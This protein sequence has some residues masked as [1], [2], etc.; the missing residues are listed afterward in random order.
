MTVVASEADGYG[1]L[2][3]GTD[4]PTCTPRPG[5]VG[6]FASL[7]PG[8]IVELLGTGDVVRGSGRLTSP[9]EAMRLLEVGML[10]CRWEVPIGPVVDDEAY[11][12]V[13]GGVRLH[14]FDGP[15]AP[16]FDVLL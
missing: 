7:A 5:A 16:R 11:A 12:L 3:D 9:V 13:V 2:H 6:G 15:A 4:G 14:T 1:G 10:R 8:A